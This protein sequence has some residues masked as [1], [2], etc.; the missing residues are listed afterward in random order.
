MS[1]EYFAAATEHEQLEWI[2]GGVM[3]ILL[4][5]RLTDG[6]L[7]VL[8]SQPAAGSAA[9]VHV[10]PNEDEI[11]VL[12]AGSAVFWV[13][14]DRYELGEG[15]VAMLPRRLPHTYRFTSET[16]DMLV[17]STPAGAEGFFRAAGR[18]LSSPRPEGWTLSPAD[19]AAAAAAHGQTVLGPPLQVDDVM[20][21][22][23]L[24]G[25]R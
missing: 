19:L 6:Q 1:L 25:E 12:L 16:A 17:I 3:S 14:K 24:E 11:V 21:A 18:N 22:G 23:Y 8:R 7:A 5:G 13:G 4:D 20:P 10:H 9:P 2:G 15:G